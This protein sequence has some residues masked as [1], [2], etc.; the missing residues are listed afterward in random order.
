MKC[1]FEKGNPALISFANASA[2]L[3]RIALA[4][5]FILS[6][7]GKL[8]ALEA[9]EAYIASVGLPFPT[10]ALLGAVALELV[11]GVALALGFWTRPAACTLA[12]YSL[13][14]AVLFHAQFGDQN[15]MIHFLKN[16]AIA[17]GLLQVVAFGAN[18][19]SLDSA[20]ERR[21]GSK[22]SQLR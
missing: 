10:L 20:L 8:A 3:G 9:T 22:D 14:T 7:A 15:Q 12:G 13:L 17:G 2:A 11:G 18:A 4:V 5:I 21:R 16:V 19:V 1:V 6:G